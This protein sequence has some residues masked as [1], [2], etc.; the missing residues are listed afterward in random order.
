[1]RDVLTHDYIGVDSDKVSNAASS[2]IPELQAESEQFLASEGSRFRN[3]SAKRA[4][5]PAGG[6]HMWVVEFEARALKSLD[7]VDFGS[8]E[9]QH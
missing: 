7:V 3:L 8:I 1:M 2:R 9:V 4:A 6:F 5:A